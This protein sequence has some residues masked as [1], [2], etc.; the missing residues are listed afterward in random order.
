MSTTTLSAGSHV[1]FASATGPSNTGPLTGSKIVNIT[2]QAA[3]QEIGFVDIAGATNGTSTSVVQGGTLLVRGWAAD[4]ATGAPVQSVS[5]FIDGLFVGTALLG[6]ARPDVAA[7]D[8]RPD[9]TNSGWTFQM[10]TSGLSLATHSVTA[11]ASGPSGTAALVGNKSFSVT[12]QAVTVIGFVDSAD[13]VAGTNTITVRGWAGDLA[14]GAPVQNVIVTVDGVFSVFSTLGVSRPDVAQALNRPDFTNSG[15]TATIFF[16]SPV[17][18][19]VFT[20]S[21]TGSSGTAPLSGVKIATFP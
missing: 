16:S 4:T 15:W 11:S 6:S 10:S 2:L 7:A 1:I 5:V 21:A 9:F 18:S 8:N 17:G 3:G 20:A 13:V 12:S 19:H 14:T